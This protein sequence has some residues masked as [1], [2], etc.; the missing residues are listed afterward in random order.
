MAIYIDSAEFPRDTQAIHKLFLAYAASLGIDLTFQSFQQ[1]LD[2]LPGQYAAREGGTL[3]IAR[4]PWQIDSH[5]KSKDNSS[6]SLNDPA[7]NSRIVDGTPSLSNIAA[8]GCV[9]LRRSTDGWCEMK[10]LYILPEA[11]GLRL[12]DKLVEAILKQA[13]LLGYRGIRLDTL[14]NMTAALHLYRKH[15]FVETG[16]YYETPIQDTIFLQCEFN[17]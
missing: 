11:R 17:Q 16:P 8:L 5:P 6:N 9:A 13:R 2:S 1:E 14:P 3:L 12:G 15:G 10:R 4:T 7:S